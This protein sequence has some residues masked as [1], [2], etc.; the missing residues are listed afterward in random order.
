M[1]TLKFTRDYPHKI[2][3]L[4]EARYLAGKTYEVSEE[5][6]QAAKKAK[7]VEVA[8]PAKSKRVRLNG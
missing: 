6:A 8:E 3:A 5:V 4:R 7:A 1:Q 2:D